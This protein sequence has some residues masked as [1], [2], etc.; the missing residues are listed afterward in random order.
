MKQ[1]CLYKGYY[2]TASST[3]TDCGR[4]QAR[5]AITAL[6]GDKT[7]SQRFLDLDHFPT[8]AEADEHAIAA[9][10]NWIDAHDGTERQRDAVGDRRAARPLSAPAR[11]GRSGTISFSA[12]R[13]GPARLQPAA[14]CATADLLPGVV[15]VWR[16]RK[17]CRSAFAPR[18]RPR[19]IC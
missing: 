3:R 12:L 9:G 13:H 19:R 16:K 4:Y 15:S 7:R 18:F 8:E 14:D 2:L 5:V 11:S 10:R 6:G 1:R 17:H